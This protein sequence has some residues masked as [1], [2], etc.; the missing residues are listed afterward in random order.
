MQPKT[1]M[2]IAEEDSIDETAPI[3]GTVGSSAARPPPP[4]PPSIFS[5]R[6]TSVKSAKVT[7]RDSKPTAERYRSRSLRRHGTEPNMLKGRSPDL[8]TVRS[9]LLSHYLRV[10]GGTGRSGRTSPSIISMQSEPESCLDSMDMRY[11]VND[12]DG[13]DQVLSESSLFVASSLLRTWSNEQNDWRACSFP[14][15]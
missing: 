9:D 13:E 4:P 1:I 14:L 7:F 2:L 8:P 11:I 10:P 3:T 12:S 5:R 15:E 6:P